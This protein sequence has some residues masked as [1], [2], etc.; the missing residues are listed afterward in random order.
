[1][2]R[3]AKS[4]PDS[5]SCSTIPARIL[6]ACIALFFFLLPVP[7]SSSKHGKKSQQKASTAFSLV[8]QPLIFP[9]R[10][11]HARLYPKHHSFSYSYLMVGIPIHSPNKENSLLSVDDKRAWWKRG[12]L[13]VEAA[14][15]LGRGGNEMG[16]YRKLQSYL[17]SQV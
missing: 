13:R 4:S 16:I 14:D 3:L 1:M 9:G 5:I 11:S 12:W 7:P 10:I 2:Q 17:E 6:A 15:H 8:D